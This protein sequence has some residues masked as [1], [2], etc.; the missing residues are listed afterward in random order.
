[1]KV[2]R[3]G[4]DPEAF[5]A[6]LRGVTHRALLLDYDGTL[7][8]FRVE[9]DLAGPYPGVLPA[10]RRILTAPGCRLA[11]IS[12]R[13][14]EDIERLIGIGPPLELW[15]SHGWERR[16]PEGGTRRWPLGEAQ[17]RGLA[18][19]WDKAVR[20]GVADRCEAKPAGL[21]LHWRGIPE[22]AAAVL[23]SEAEEA[24]AP[25]AAETALELHPFDGGLELRAAGRDK[26]DAVRSLLDELGEDAAI[27]YLGD[28][29]TDEAA[30]QALR[31]HGLSALVRLEPRETAA[32]LWLKPPDELLEFLNRWTRECEG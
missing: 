12:G 26:G 25:L 5:F 31:G 29:R 3:S 15:G 30:F 7:A 8:P 32:D 20:M 11:I 17:L 10:L 23:R 14:L 2:M 4:V 28:D 13:S 22:E 6:S 21:A 18:T 19:A 27:A 24:W 16:D 1:M 9:R